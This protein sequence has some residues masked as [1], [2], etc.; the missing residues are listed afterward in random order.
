MRGNWQPALRASGVADEAYR[1]SLA[2]AA[3]RALTEG[4]PVGLLGQPGA[5][6]LDRA[7]TATLSVAAG[8]SLVKMLPTGL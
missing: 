1:L 2:P 6:P 4:P 5:E 8:E 7:R 3:R